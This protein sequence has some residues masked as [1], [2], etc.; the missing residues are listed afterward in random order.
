MSANRKAVLTW[1]ILLV[2]L[3]ITAASSRF[4]LGFANVSINLAIAAAKAGLVLVIFM[5][6]SHRVILTRLVV[7]CAGLWLAILYSLTLIDYASR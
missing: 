2:F 4:D 3:A 1:T 7:A 6:L 5:H